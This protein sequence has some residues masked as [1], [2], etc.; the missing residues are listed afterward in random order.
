MEQVAVIPAAAR[1]RAAARPSRSAI[2]WYAAGSVGTGAYG[3]VPGLV[4]LYFMTNVLGVAPVL[5][6]AALVVPKLLDVVL[7]P[8]VGLLAD[9]GH[10]RRLVLAGALTLPLLFVALFAVP[11]SL[12]GAGAA[13]YV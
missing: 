8:L 10:E 13:L 5:A 4:L 6:G 7:H 11:P 2:G 3:T 1:E 9:R 12:T